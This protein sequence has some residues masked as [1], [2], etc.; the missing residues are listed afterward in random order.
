MNVYY[1]SK[2]HNVTRVLKKGV[3]FIKRF[4]KKVSLKGGYISSSASTARRRKR[5]KTRTWRVA[6]KPRKT[7]NMTSRRRKRKRKTKGNK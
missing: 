7:R 6:N 4:T 5:R 3:D 2:M 1:K